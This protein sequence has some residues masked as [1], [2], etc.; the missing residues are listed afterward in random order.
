MSVLS[1]APYF[2]FCRAKLTRQSVAVEADM[3]WLEAE[4]DLRYRPVC[5]VCGGAGARVHDWGKRSLRDLN[6]GAAQVWIGC[7][8][9]KIYCPACGKVRVEDLEFFDP[10]KRVTQRLA[11]YI[12]E[13]CKVLTVK[14][15][16]EHLQLDWKTVKDID[17]SFLERRYD[18]TDYSDLTI[19]AVDEIAIRKG[20]QYMT[21]VMDSLTGRVVWLGKDRTAETLM[22]FFDGMSDAQKQALQAI[23]MDMWNPY[24]LAVQTKAPHVQIVFDLFHVVAA[25]NQVIDKVRNDE[26]RKASDEDKAVFK[27]AKYLLLKNK[28]KIRRRKHREHLRRLLELNQTI[29]TMMI[30]KDL[31]KQIWGYRR[32]GWAARRIAEWCT[33]ARTLD[34]PEVNTFARRLE[35]HDYGILNHCDYPIHTGK[36]EGTNNKIKVIKRKAYGFHDQHYFALKVLQAF[37]PL[38]RR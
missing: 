12:H 13:L 19:L 21:V 30:L 10:Y 18:K 22:D 11:R 24:I 26:Y 31:L 38:N 34:H 4:P 1:I 37:D 32:R 14:E 27:G 16:A 25:F 2:P 9:R 23:A 35:R 6:L 33:L 3:A 7:S 8:F 36:L 5:H 29:S 28:K 17:K 15:V 20:H